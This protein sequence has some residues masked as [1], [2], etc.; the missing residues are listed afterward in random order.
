MKNVLVYLSTYNGEKY[1][2]PLLDS[3]LAQEGVI[4]NIFIRDDGSSDS[5]R[6][7]LK[8]YAKANACIEVAFEENI[9]YAKSFWKLFQAD[10]KFDYYAFCDQDDIWHKDKLISAV[11]LLEAERADEKPL[12]YTSDVIAINNDLKVIDDHFFSVTGVLSFYQSLQKSIL[13]GCTFVFNSRAFEVLSKYNG[14]MESHD[15]ATYCII[16]ALGKV[17]YDAKPYIQYRIHENNTIGRSNKLIELLTRMKRLFHPPKR[18][19][20]CF[21]KDF[22]DC[23][24]SVLNHDYAMAAKQLGYYRINKKKMELLRNKRFKERYFKLMVLLGRV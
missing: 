3:V 2:K 10:N 22:F 9:G 21:A 4:V 13:P 18:S 6:Q 5:T 11:K 23:Y 20:S 1:L 16:S 19:R 14:Y 17:V 24:N 7:I 15:W 12:L 8:E